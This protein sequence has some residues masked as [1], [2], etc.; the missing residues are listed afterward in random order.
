[1]GSPLFSVVLPVKD[2]EDTLGRAIESIVNQSFTDWELIVVV[3]GSTDGTENVARSYENE[4]IKVII[5]EEAGRSR[6]RNIGM[7]HCVGEYIVFLDGDDSYKLNSLEEFYN[8]IKCNRDVDII[9]ST[10]V[11]VSKGISHGFY[12]IRPEDLYSY[13]YNVGLCSTAF[14][15]SPFLRSQCGK[16]YRRGMLEENEITFDETLHYKEDFHFNSN[17][18]KKCKSAIILDFSLYKIRS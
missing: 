1:M 7:K 8:I 4:K 17:V 6:A 5:V 10:L 16:A 2:M 13:L 9:C 11:L 14:K 12:S 15:R 18:Y 3:N